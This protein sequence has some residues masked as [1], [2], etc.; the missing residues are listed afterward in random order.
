MLS[1]KQELHARSTPPLGGDTRSAGLLFPTYTDQ[2]ALP[3]ADGAGGREREGPGLGLAGDLG[4]GF[5]PHP[6]VS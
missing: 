4:S 5:A 2:N 6:A 3:R 1:L